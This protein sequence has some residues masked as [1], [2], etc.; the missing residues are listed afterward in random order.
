M[1]EFQKWCQEILP[2]VQAAAKG[3]EVEFWDSECDVWR[4]KDVSS[5]SISMRYRIKPKTIKIGEYDVPEPCREAL[6]YGERYWVVGIMADSPLQ[7][8]SW[9]GDSL[10]TM[11]L[12]RGL[13]HRT[14]EAAELHT[15]VLISLT[16]TK[17]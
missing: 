16:A 8:W 2:I 1:N 15:K 5:L 3:H 4:T 13:L 7:S 14:K 11:W 6:E 12:E 17:E 10:A 9:S